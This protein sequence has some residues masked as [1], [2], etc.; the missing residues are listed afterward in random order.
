MFAKNILDQLS[1][2]RFVRLILQDAT[3]LVAGVLE[4]KLHIVKPLAVVQILGVVRVYKRIVKAYKKEPRCFGN[5]KPI[6]ILRGEQKQVSGPVRKLAAVH[7]LVPGAV[8]NINQLKKAVL[9]SAFRKG[10][11]FP[12]FALEWPVKIFACHIRKNTRKRQIYTSIDRYFSVPFHQMRILIIGAGGTIGKIVTEDLVRDH[13]VVTAGRTSGDVIVD[14]ASAQEIEDLYRLNDAFDAV[15]CAAGESD[16]CELP[17]LEEKHLMLGIKQKLLAQVNLVLIGQKYVRDG[18]SF[19]LTTGKMG[20]L[21]VKGSA[22]K[23]FVNGAIN[24]FVMAAAL[25]LQRGLRIN[26]VSPAKI[27]SVSDESVAAAYRRAVEEKING[28]VLRIYQ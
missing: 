18:A 11:K 10:F 26:A 19:T 24:S 25:D 5:L 22:G 2:D 28:E 3:R 23:S 15:I 20:D 9:P 4:D 7:M 13:E 27:G 17:V 12:Q 14:I 8:K 21:P 6:D 1:Y 16:S